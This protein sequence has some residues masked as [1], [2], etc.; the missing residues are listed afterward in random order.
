MQ[1]FSLVI[2]AVIALLPLICQADPRRTHVSATEYPFSAI[3]RLNVGN[4]SF[5][6]A[7]LVAERLVLTAA[8]C[9]WLP[10]E[11]RWW[12]PSAVHFTPSYQGG[13]MPLHSLAARY[14]VADCAAD[15]GDRCAGPRHFD[16]D[17]AVIELAEPLGLAA[18]WIAVGA[19]RGSDLIGRVGYH[20]ASRDAMTLDYGCK[21][22]GPPLPGGGEQ[23]FR[24]DCG[25]LPGTSGGP[26]LAFAADGPR[27]IGITTASVKGTSYAQAVSVPAAAFADRAR[28]PAA[29]QILQSAGVGRNA[30]HAPPSGALPAE[31]IKILDP[32]NT[33]PPSFALLQKLLARTGADQAPAPWP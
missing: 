6:S 28:F 13:D 22:V 21:V 16:A 11:N 25:A 1:R 33:A 2:C 10:S 18:G 12:P 24:D 27:L 3:G 14:A 7:V 20:K 30:G 15:N 31:T 23:L 5:C 17:W 8:H 29:A 26:V 19:A 4:H 9:L 32:G